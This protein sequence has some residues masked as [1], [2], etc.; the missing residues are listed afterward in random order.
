MQCEKSISPFAASA[1]PWVRPTEKASCWASVVVVTLLTFVAAYLFMVVLFHLVLFAEMRRKASPWQRN[2]GYP[3]AM[4]LLLA[5]TVPAAL[6]RIFKVSLIQ[7]N[8][9]SD[10][11]VFI[12]RAFSGDVCTDGVFQRV[13]VAPGRNGSASRDG[14]ENV[15]GKNVSCS[16]SA[17]RPP[18]FTDDCCRFCFRTLTWGWPLSPCSARWVRQFKWSSSCILSSQFQWM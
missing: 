17:D 10:Y 5:L 1:S 14:G 15:A 12:A 4:L 7:Q 9:R 16:C 11:C 13:G 2:L 6:L 18:A 3:L 8:S